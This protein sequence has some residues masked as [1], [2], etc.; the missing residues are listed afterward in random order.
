MGKSHTLRS[1]RVYSLYA[2]LQ[3]P[4]QQDHRQ[5]LHVHFS[6]GIQLFAD[7]VEVLIVTGLSENA[8]SGWTLPPEQQEE[9][10]KG[11]KEDGR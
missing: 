10:L 1:V 3:Q 5:G 11:K 2:H 8:L 6:P 7:C 9:L 4:N